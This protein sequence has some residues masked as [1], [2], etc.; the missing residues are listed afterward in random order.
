MKNELN[1]FIHADG[2][3]DAFKYDLTLL[4]EAEL[5]TTIET[6]KQKESDNKYQKQV[7]KGLTETPCKIAGANIGQFYTEQSFSD[8]NSKIKGMDATTIANALEAQEA[9]LAKGDLTS[10]ENMLLS[11]SHTLNT[12]FADMV[13]KMAGAKYLKNLEVYGRIA[14]KAQNQTRQDKTNSIDI[15]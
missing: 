6:Q 12:I 8:D 14:L 1:Y 7:S 15:D 10:L 3:T 13:F 5:I 2:I 4:E 9:L 11:Q